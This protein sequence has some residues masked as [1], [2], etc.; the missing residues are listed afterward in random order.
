MSGLAE[1]LRQ[2]PWGQKGCQVVWDARGG[3]ARATLQEA[4]AHKKQPVTRWR[5]GL[6]VV[7]GDRPPA[8]AGFSC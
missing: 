8:C 1:V 6:L 3:Q 5:D 4:P 7:E 2:E